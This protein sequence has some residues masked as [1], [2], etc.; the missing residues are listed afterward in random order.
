MG[1]RR[2]PLVARE[3]TMMATK[4][5]K[6]SRAASGKAVAK[7]L[8]ANTAVDAAE[9]RRERARAAYQALKEEGGKA[10]EAMLV[11]ARERAARFHERRRKAAKKAQARGKK[12]GSR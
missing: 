10:Y 1:S 2:G 3:E 11:K 7:A 6:G 4:K 9:Q 12:A 8:T 5:S